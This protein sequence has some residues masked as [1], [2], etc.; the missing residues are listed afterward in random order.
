MFS[1]IV[2]GKRTGVWETRAMRERSV[3]VCSVLI[4]W[5]ETL[6]APLAAGERDGLASVWYS[7]S[8]IDAIVDFPEPEDPTM[9][10]QLPRAMLKE[11]S[12][13]TCTSGRVGYAKLTL[14]SVMSPADWICIVPFS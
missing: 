1:A 6:I 5:L 4:S 10:V 13:S 8:S 12:V 14:L 2:P 9:V 11:T 3:V 7:L